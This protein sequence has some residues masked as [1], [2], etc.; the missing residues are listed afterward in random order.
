MADKTTHTA[1]P[2]GSAYCRDRHLVGMGKFVQGSG[3][4]VEEA[5]RICTALNRE[6]SPGMLDHVAQAYMIGSITHLHG[7]GLVGDAEPTVG[8]LTQSMQAGI[9]AAFKAAGLTFADER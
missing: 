6:L 7:L 5:E 2:C 4:T 1:C 9:R 3:F 8:Q